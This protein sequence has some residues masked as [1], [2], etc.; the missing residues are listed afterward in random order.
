MSLKLESI[1]AASPTTTRGTPTPLSSDSKGERLTYASNKS[2]FVRSIDNPSTAKQ[3][4]AHTAATTVARFS[5]SGYYIASGD[6]TGTVRVWDSIGAETTKGEYSIIAGRI[7]DIAWDGDSQRIIAVG[8]GKE[9]GGACITADS[10][11]SVGEISGHSAQIN[12]VSIRQQRPLRAATG[13]DDTTLCFFHGAPFKFNTSVRGKHDKYIYGTHFSPDGSLLVSVGSDRRIWLYDGKT[14]DAVKQVGEGEHKGSIFG[15][16]WAGDS[17]RLV[18]CSGDQTV[19]IWDVEAGKCTRSWRMGE[20]GTVSVPDQQV[21]VTWPGGRQD[22]L[23]ISVDLEGNLNYFQES[24]QKPVRI[25]RGH[26]KAI[27]A[28]TAASL[29]GGSRTL[30]T[31]SYDGRIRSWDL[32]TN[33]GTA[34][35]IE[36]AGHSNYIAGLAASPH[37]GNEGRIFSIAWDD[38]LRTIASHQETFIGTATKL[39][40]QPKG[41]AIASLNGQSQ[42]LVA[43]ASVIKAYAEGEQVSSQALPSPPVCLAAAGETVAAGCE[44]TSVRIFSLRGPTS[45]DA[46]P[47]LTEPTHAISALAFSPDASHLAVGTSNGKIYVYSSSSSS[48]SSSTSTASSWSLKTNRWSAHTARVTA[49]SWSPDG[50]KAVSGGLDTNVFVWSLAEP[51]KRVKAL[52]AHKEGMGGVVW[53]DDGGKGRVVSCGADAAVRVWGVEGVV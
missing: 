19:K 3:Y 45:F 30:W 10:G 38:T 23:V 13:S 33:A 42:T 12:C 49:I 20:E 17:K 34:H 40:T 41:V 32:S 24:S 15:V 2:I 46:M 16:S 48:S 8:D 5:P 31:G 37:K 7:N 36:G 53:V 44:D 22:G 11:N 9:R 18:T 21:G 4:T 27:T 25:V 1:W 39:P 14:G 50:T 52:N 26:Q 47:T 28:A 51:G 29:D 43:T 6:V 35:E